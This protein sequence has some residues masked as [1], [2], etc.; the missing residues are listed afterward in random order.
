M[1]RFILP[2]IVSSAF[3]LSV[4]V[5]HAQSGFVTSTTNSVQAGDTTRV[6]VDSA[7][8]EGNNNSGTPSISSNGRYVAFRSTASNLV[9]GDGNGHTDVFVHDRQ[10]GLTTRVSV[11]SAGAEGNNLSIEPSISAD[12][13]CVAFASFAS[14]LVT[15]DG[16]GEDVFVH[17]LRT[18]LTT[19]VSVDSAGAEGNDFS[20][21][22]S[23]SSNG[24]YVAFR[25]IASNLVPGDGNGHSDVFVH[26][27]WTG[28]TTRV[29]LDSAGAEG[30]LA[31]SQPSISSNGRC[32]AFLSEASNLVPG[33]GNGGID[34]F[35]HDR[36][37]GLTTRVSVDSAGAEGNSNSG[38]PSISSTGRY[39]AFG[40]TAS[41]F[42]PEDGNNA[43]D[44]FV[45]DRRTGLTTRVSVDS[46]GAEGN[47]GSTVPSIS[48]N[49]HYVAFASLATNLVPEDGNLA[50]DIFVHDRQTGLTTRVSVNSAGAEGD[51]NSLEP[52][53]SSSG[54][55][56]AFHSGASNLV[57][58]DGN[59]EVD[60]FVHGRR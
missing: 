29:S 25:S 42:V 8:A 27:R 15:G 53:I 3:L 49:G 13:S 17:D 16:N 46:A 35:V 55:Y 40:S 20:R 37:T 36:Q 7:G 6:S 52:S 22:P 34:V 43:G 19:R 23:I 12:G 38:P 56:V 39:V 44:I 33:D 60:C 57:P 30:N 10:T 24:R 59:G 48:A 31:S 28:L 58:G 51:S 9:P 50:N 5:T 26:D 4:A 54:R 14:N 1:K 11:D 2:G 18:G 41:N 47:S 21:E 32:V 45:H